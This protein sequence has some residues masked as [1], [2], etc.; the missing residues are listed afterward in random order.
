MPELNTASLPDLV[1]AFLFFIMMVT[2]MRE[3][4]PKISY[5]NLPN[6]TEL[7]KLEEKSLVTF[8]YIGKPTDAYKA[9]YGSNS[10]IQ[11]NDQL[12][13]D[14]KAVYSYVK[15]AEGK[16]RDDRKKLMQISIKADRTT[17]MNIISEVKEQLRKADALNVSYSSRQP[18]DKK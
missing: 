11:L 7:T 3:V 16:I 6:A 1:F 10:A 8:I 5:S 18:A 14:A 17:K 13:Q 15:Q 4:T 2:S 9:K 12:T